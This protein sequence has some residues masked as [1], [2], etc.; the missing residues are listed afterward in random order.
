LTSGQPGTSGVTV[1]PDPDLS[2]PAGGAYEWQHFAYIIQWYLFALLALAAPFA[3]SRTEV[4]DAQQRF[5]G[6][7][8]ASEELGLERGAEHADQLRLSA[9]PSPGGAIA[10]RNDGTVA[11]RSAPTPQWQRAARLADR[12]GRSLGIGPGATA[13][14]TGQMD[15]DRR[16]GQPRQAAVFESHDIPNSATQPHRSD[17]A[18]HGSYNDYLWELGL[19]D[20]AI[21]P[22]SAR[23]IEETHD[24]LRANQPEQI[25]DQ[26]SFTAEDTN[27]P[28][29][30]DE[31][32]STDG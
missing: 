31:S 6:I 24:H 10:V 12:Y 3:I 15:H 32:S 23:R 5:L 19:A 21:P 27:S 20:G 8:P 26:R 25:A 1:L 17:D 28:P 18:Y 13:E 14:P 2:N 29:T 7:D 22:V 4:R 11:A 30:D 16:D 9:G